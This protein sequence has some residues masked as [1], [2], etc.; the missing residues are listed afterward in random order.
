MRILTHSSIM[1]AFQKM[2]C[3]AYYETHTSPPDSSVNRCT[4]REVEARMAREI[5]LIGALTLLCGLVN[6][7]IT[8]WSIKRVGVK[9]ALFVQVLIPGVRLV[10]QNIG[11]MVGSN[12]GIII[13]QASQITTVVGGPIGYVL[14]LNSFITD[15]VEHEERTG[16]L[17]KL[18]G[19][20]KYLLWMNASSSYA[21]MWH[22]PKPLNKL[23]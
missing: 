5:T 12:A 10:I 9:N 23:Y 16:A 13:M 15:T 20:R 2:T 19:C 6:L 22:V 14:A 11:V 17:G 3:D 8:G 7:L 4:I 21:A 18:Q 1:Y